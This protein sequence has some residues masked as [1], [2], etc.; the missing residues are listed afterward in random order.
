MGGSG[1]T[2]TARGSRGGRSTA[3]AA[4]ILHD[5][6][7][8]LHGCLRDL[9]SRTAARRGRQ[10]SCTDLAVTDVIEMRAEHHIRALERCVRAFDHA[11]DV[12]SP[13]FGH[14]FERVID[15]DRDRHGNRRRGERL[16]FRGF[17]PEIGKAARC[18]GEH[19][20]EE[21]LIADDL[22]N[23]GRIDAL[24]SGEIGWGKSTA[25]ACAGAATLQLRLRLLHSLCRFLQCLPRLGQ[26][27]LGVGRVR[28]RSKADCRGRAVR[29]DRNRGTTAP[30]SPSCRR[31]R[32]EVR[33]PD[34]ELA[35][36]VAILQ[37]GDLPVA[38]ELGAGERQC[39]LAAWT[40]GKRH[41]IAMLE[42]PRRAIRGDCHRRIA[43]HF[44][45]SNPD[46]FEVRAS[47]TQR[48]HAPLFQQ[49]G[50]VRRRKAVAFRERLAALELVGREIAQP[51][52]HVFDVDL[53]ELDPGPFRRL[54]EQD[55]SGSA[56]AHKN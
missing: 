40:D 19:R 49:A 28:H 2:R 3:P 5:L 45:A 43:S 23:R 55:A 4:G 52:A 33:H 10:H 50:H 13:L 36:H 7:C 54:R 42:G 44:V 41:V 38:D 48:L 8:R 20:F 6:S 37:V 53:R 9:A 16:A 25:S 22:R 56:R 26:R 29:G 21:R 24:S 11:H 12:P 32:C 1:G 35:L 51:L 31:R 46:A 27:A 30:A 34:H 15:V 39:L 14:S 17:R 18:S 47:V